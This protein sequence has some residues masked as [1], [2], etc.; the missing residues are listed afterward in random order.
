MDGRIAV[1]AAQ[2]AALSGQ[3]PGAGEANRITIL[4]RAVVVEM[5]TFKAGDA[6]CCPP[7]P[8]TRRY[9]VAA[10]KLTLATP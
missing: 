5:L 2:L 10:G 1:L 8:V 7:Q 4:Q 6:A 9:R 3:G